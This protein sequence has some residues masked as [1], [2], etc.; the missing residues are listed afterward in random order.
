MLLVILLLVSIDGVDAAKK[1]KGSKKAAAAAVAAERASVDASQNAAPVSAT[2]VKATI[3]ATHAEPEP[4]QQ[5]LT[6]AEVEA[7]AARLKR[8]R[9]AVKKRREKKALATAAALR[10]AKARNAASAAR[11]AAKVARN[12]KAAVAAKA[13]AD[14]LVAK[15]RAA[16]TPEIRRRGHEKLRWL[17]SQSAKTGSRIIAFDTAAYN[18]YVHNSEP[19]SRSHE[20]LSS[21][22]F[23][24]APFLTCCLH[25]CP[26]WLM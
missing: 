24:P 25:V 17:L 21:T 2:E 4:V 8:R 3:D 14:E 18:A 20:G 13:R 1:K 12:A 23:F 15:K 22:V 26:F 16:D 10:T 11:R 7:A 5:E 19:Q 6:P 9:E